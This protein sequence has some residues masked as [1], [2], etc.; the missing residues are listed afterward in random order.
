MNKKIVLIL[1]FLTITLVGCGNTTDFDYD[2]LEQIALKT[3]YN[4]KEYILEKEEHE[5]FITKLNNYKY[6]RHKGI[7]SKGEYFI[8]LKYNDKCI[9]VGQYYTNIYNK[10]GSEIIEGFY[11]M[12]E[13][14]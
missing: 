13:D 12:Y 11:R 7:R 1:L 9:E 3:A 14:D 8:I 5:E 4:D 6:K 2:N 10:D